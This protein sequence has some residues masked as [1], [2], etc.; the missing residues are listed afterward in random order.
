M[1]AGAAV[2]AVLAFVLFYLVFLIL[3]FRMM[4]MHCCRSK[5]TSNK[6][7]KEIEK[8]IKDLNKSFSLMGKKYFFMSKSEYKGR[9]SRR[10]I[11]ACKN[12]KRGEKFSDKNI[13]IIRPGYGIKPLYFEKIINKKSPYAIKPN[14]PLKKDLLKKLKL[15]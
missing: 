4:F 15:I 7:L 13:K 12:I 1:A 14:V 6:K 10:S 2:L 3:I 9:L 5:K 8:Y 11:Y